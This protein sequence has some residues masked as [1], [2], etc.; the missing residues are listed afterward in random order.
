[1]EVTC[2]NINK[3]KGQYFFIWLALCQKEKRNFVTSIRT[4]EEEGRHRQTN[5]CKSDLNSHPSFPPL[6]PHTH[7]GSS[8]SPFCV[9]S[10]WLF[11]ATCKC[12]GDIQNYLLFALCLQDNTRIAR[13][14]QALFSGNSRGREKEWGEMRERERERV[15]KRRK[16]GERKERER[17]T[18]LNKQSKG[19]K[20]VF[21]PIG[22]VS[23]PLLLLQHRNET[24]AKTF[25]QRT[26]DKIKCWDNV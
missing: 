2:F 12:D 16:R 25:S 26:E 8:C 23:L 6:T 15:E 22:N 1:M 4:A 20:F 17:L 19:N 11:F 24:F 14:S 10:V 7:P 3:D 9:R 13:D 18:N 5:K 21:V